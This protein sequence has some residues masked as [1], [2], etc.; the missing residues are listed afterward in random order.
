MTLHYIQ[1]SESLSLALLLPPL[2]LLLLRPLL[3]T[4][5]NT[6]LGNVFPFPFPFPVASP[7]TSKLA[8]PC[9]PVGRR[10]FFC[11]VAHVIW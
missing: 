7:L 9:Q 6:L 8:L 1:S 2:L 5:D 3:V 10:F 4:C 11:C